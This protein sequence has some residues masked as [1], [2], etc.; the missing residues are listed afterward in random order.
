MGFAAR[1][2]D[3]ARIGNLIANRGVA[4][5]KTI[6]S[7]S[8]I[9]EF[10]TWSDKDSQCRVGVAGSWFGYKANMWHI[11]PNGKMPFFNGHHAQRLVIHLPTKTV[12]VQTGVEHSGDWQ[13]E[14]FTIFRSA[15]LI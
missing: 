4:N 6:I 12:L 7:E 15:A 3:W 14:L 13:K 10:T 1:T 2:R 9:N 8:W 5:D 11:W